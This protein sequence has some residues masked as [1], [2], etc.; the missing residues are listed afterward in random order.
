MALSTMV[1]LVGK[2][3]SLK[4]P[5]ISENQ[6]RE[7][8]V[9][10]NDNWDW[11]GP[12]S[13]VNWQG[14]LYR[15]EQI[16]EASMVF[17]VVL[18]V[19]EFLMDV[20]A[21][22]WLSDEEKELEILLLRQQLRI[23]ERK[24]PR[25]A[26]CTVA[27]GA[28]GD[29]SGSAERAGKEWTDS[30]EASVRLFR[31]ATVVGWHPG[32]RAAEM[33]LSAGKTPGRPPIDAELERWILQVARDNPGLGYE[34]LA[35]ELRKL[36][37]QVSKTTVSIV[38]ERHGVPPAPERGRRGQFVACLPQ[39]LQGP[40]PGV[41]LFHCRDLD[42]AHAVCPFLS[43][44]WHATGASGWLYRPSHWGVGDPASAAD[45]VVVTGPRA[46]NGLFDPRPRHQVHRR[47]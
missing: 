20:L 35:G 47:V 39:S 16:A 12:V 10:E 18:F 17:R 2:P 6:S 44:A 8:K 34:K 33:D 37:F 4:Y 7:G 38:L 42:P 1:S 14:F 30:L 5:V 3:Q 24:Q 41:R 27:E 11:T 9:H 31:P 22:S 15:A 43:G 36:G 40:V 19:W 45:D 23:V 13:E 28:A 21:V 26:N 32:H 29:V 25:V 46:A